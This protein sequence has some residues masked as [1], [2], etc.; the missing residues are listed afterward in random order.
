MLSIRPDLLPP[1]AVYELQKLC[2]AVPSYPTAEALAL[3]AAEL[4][5]PAGDVF[6]DLNE[7]SVPI[8]AA[9]LGQVYRCRLRATG[10]LVAVKVQRPDMIR[11]VSLDLY[12]LRRYM[13]A[14]EWFKEEVCAVAHDIWPHLHDA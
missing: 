6:E 9:S 11:A 7:S 12:L 2:D 5:R 8:A 14:V 10:E 1:A 3:V 13:Q 4:G